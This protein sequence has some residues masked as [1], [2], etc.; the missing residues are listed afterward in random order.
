[1]KRGLEPSGPSHSALIQKLV[2]AAAFIGPL[3]IIPQVSEIWFV[4]HGA[5]GV[6]LLT[7]SSFSLLSL[8]W[9]LYGLQR[10]DRPLII[11]NALWLVG[12]LIVVAGAIHYDFDF[13]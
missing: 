13:L 2:Y 10:R 7:W 1:M 5:K 6:S 3:S 9:L 4:D 8:V 11:S 12:E